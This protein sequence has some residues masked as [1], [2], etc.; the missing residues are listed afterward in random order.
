MK[1]P[2]L[3][4]NRRP[5]RVL[6]V[7]GG[8]H[9][10]WP[11]R[12]EDALRIR[13]CLTRKLVKADAVLVIVGRGFARDLVGHRVGDDVTRRLLSEALH[14]GKRIVPVL[15][16][17]ARMHEIDELT[18]DHQALSYQHALTAE[19]DE[20]IPGIVARVL[21]L[22]GRSKMSQ[23][24]H[25][26]R[27]LSRQSVFV[28]Y[29]RDDTAYWAGALS[30]ALALRVGSEFLFFDIGSEEPGRDYRQQIEDALTRC[31]TFVIVIGSGFLEPDATG[32]RRIDQ[33]S[34]QVRKEIARALTQHKSIHVVLTGQASMPAAEELPAD[35]RGLA[36]IRS[37]Y[38]L[39]SDDDINAIADAIASLSAKA[40]PSGVESVLTEWWQKQR[41]YKTLARSVVAE[42][43][44]LDWK[45][46]SEL[47]GDCYVLRNNRFPLFRLKLQIKLAEVI[48]EEH[49]KSGR[50]FGFRRWVKRAVFSTSP[51]A[52][53]T[54]DLLRLP[55]R[56][57]E[58]A[59]DP[60]QYLARTG[61]VVLPKRMRR[62]MPQDTFLSNVKYMTVPNPSAIDSYQKTRR[63]IYSRGGLR[64]LARVRSLKFDTDGFVRGVAFH[65]DGE[66]LA[67]ASNTGV[68][69]VSARDG[70]TTSFL[71]APGL[72][73]SVAFSRNGHLAVGS[74]DG[75][76]SLWDSDGSVIAD[77][78]S[79]YSLWQRAY[80]RLGSDHRKLTTVSWSEDCTVVACCGVDTVWFYDVS[81]G[82]FMSWEIPLPVH[83]WSRDYGAQ[84]IPGRSEVVV[85]ELSHVWI[86]R[87]PKLDVRVKTTMPNRP[88]RMGR[89]LS[90]QPHARLK[91]APFYGVYDVS[92]S[93]CGDVVALAGTDG[94]MAIYSL[95][96]L[97]Q[98]NKA[99]WY[100]PIIKG[101]S[102][103]VELV[104]FSPDARWL[105]SVATDHR[106][107]VGQAD[108]LE[109]IQECRVQTSVHGIHMYPKMAWSPDSL[110][111]ATNSIG[112]CVEIWQL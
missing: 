83:T 103:Q 89:L 110:M 58:A 95:D 35:I 15:V 73:Q 23:A 97:K 27:L 82:R 12:F 65:P 100:E 86:V 67:I 13:D 62:M 32:T 61:R 11:Q 105:A 4:S 85:F 36:A 75:R 80:A 16:E 47:E 8:S 18:G 108:S 72:W 14:A 9:G 70:Q 96:S 29:R 38:R 30:H 109:P 81:R 49:V 90:D 54:V 104:S 33:P 6:V 43:A 88:K 7:S 56:L 98:L 25:D 46:E 19:T 51:H 66:R 69:L 39:E 24:P 2:S 111:I 20:D 48:L 22:S 45:P 50:S 78:L 102:T 40:H 53:S 37:I 92:P 57:L 93:P 63:N 59:L 10:N 26:G 77:R 41:A 3:I 112:G 17:G 99:A 44:G 79:P 91:D 64:Q 76:I 74:N 5:C 1:Q 55:D 101:F 28:S 106:L 21:A 68:S 84:F 52:P 34:D 42:L 94:Q 71:P 60:D 31:T 87:L 107:I